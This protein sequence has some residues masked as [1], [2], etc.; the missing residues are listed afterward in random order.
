[1]LFWGTVFGRYF[2]ILERGRH[3]CNPRWPPCISLVLYLYA[4]SC[5][6][7][8]L[9]ISCFA[10]L[11]PTVLPSPVRENSKFNAACQAMLTAEDTAEDHPDLREIRRRVASNMAEMVELGFV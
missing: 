10:T 3:W 7:L 11:S 4:F 5:K 6:S 9:G 1:M 2:G 8:S